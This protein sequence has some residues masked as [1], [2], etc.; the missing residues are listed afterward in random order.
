MVGR[1]PTAIRTAEA[2]G[3]LAKPDI[4]PNNRRYGYTLAEINAMRRHFGTLPYRNLET[5]EAIV[6]A[7]QNFKGGCGK[8]TITAHLSQYLALQGYRVCVIDADPQAS[9]TALFG[10]NPDVDIDEDDTL[11]PFFSGETDDIGYAIRDTHW[12]QLKLI[13]ANLGLY[14]AEYGIAAAIST[15][16]S[17]NAADHFLRLKSGVAG[18]AHQFD[19]VIIDAPPALGMI[20]LSILNCANS[21]LIPVRPASI[22]FSSTGNFFKMLIET[23]EI[24]SSRGIA[25]PRFKFLKVMANDMD[26]GKSAHV[27]ISTMMQEVFGSNI[28]STVMKDSAEIDNAGARLQTVYELSGPITSRET[29]NRCKAYLNAANREVEILIR[30]SWPSHKASLRKEGLL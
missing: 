8:S 10:F 13:P 5:D 19:I 14:S 29:H 27:A 3:D 25:E 28:L 15:D 22:D 2:N 16:K 23:Y 17:V 20:S 11:L 30:K 21:L 18:V 4:G 1:S 7:V 9:T 24:L 12:D 26:E 6:L